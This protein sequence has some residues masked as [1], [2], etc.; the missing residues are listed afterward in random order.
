MTHNHVRFGVRSLDG[1]TTDIW[2]CWTPNGTGKRDVYLT[3]RPLGHAMKLSLHESRRWHVGFHAVKKDVLFSPETAPPSRF[4]GVWDRSGVSAAPSVLAARVCF[5]WSSPSQP[6]CDAPVGTR[7]LACAGKGEMVEVAIFLVNVPVA[8]DDWPGKSA[9][10]ADLVGR[11]PLD[12][13]GEVIIVSRTAEMWQESLAKS[14][15]PSYFRG[16]SKADLLE[17]NRIVAWGDSP[18]GSITFI[19]TILASEHGDA[20]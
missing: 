17:A 14:G 20:A 9:M 5:P 4:L 6:P 8:R 3:S 19:E 15:T 12:G 16:K 2:K 7:W 13:G 1:A 11:I 18:D 10:G